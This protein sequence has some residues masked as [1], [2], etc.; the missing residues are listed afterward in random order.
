MLSDSLLKYACSIAY[1]FKETVFHTWDTCWQIVD[2]KIPGDFVECGVGAGAQTIVMY[3]IGAG[4]DGRTV[5]G[6]DSFE[7]I[8]LAGEHDEQQPG[9]GTITHNK[10]ASI[11]ERLVSSG[12]TSHSVENVLKN[13]ETAGIF[14]TERLKLIKGWFQN[15]IPL[16]KPEKIALLRLD[17]DLY[18]STLICLQNLYPL[19]VDGGFIIIDDY[20]LPGCKKA[21]RDYF[22]EDEPRFFNVP[23]SGGV[24]YWRK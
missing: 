1:S 11:K 2:E 8:P 18:E 5:W 6:Y 17:G 24:I 3:A 19:V 14:N 22:D 23:G 21:V 20:A 16:N 15:T 12:V 9:I 13:F 4:I 10:T 7:G